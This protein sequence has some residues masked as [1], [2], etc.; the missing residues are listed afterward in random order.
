MTLERTKRISITKETRGGEMRVLLGPEQVRMIVEHGYEVL[1]ERAAGEGAGWSD[2]AYGAAG[3]RI[4]STD[5]AWQE[6]DF[7]VKYKNPGPHEYKYF[8]PGLHLGAYMHAEG[9]PELSEAMRANGVT[10][11]AWEFYRCESGTFPLTLTDNQIA[12]QMAVLHGAYY[13]QTTFGG[14]GV[15]MPR[16]PGAKP[17]KVVVIGHGN[18]GGAAAR[19]AAAMGAEVVV[20]GRRR[21]G[22]HQ[23]AASM[24]AN[25]RCVMNSPERLRAEVEDA[26]LVIGTILISNHETPAMIDADLV[27]AMRPGSMIVDVT[28][29]YGPGYLPTA[30]ALSYHKD[31]VY[32]RYGVLHCKIDAFPSSVPVS[33]AAATSANIAP[34]LVE[35]GDTIHAGAELTPDHGL[36]VKDYRIVHPVM[37][38]TLPMIESAAE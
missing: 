30:D 16:V 33:A 23:F 26:D 37:L 15:L 35:L 8:R 5:E 1:L 11:F 27:D 7:V 20:F 34:Y 18:V 9:N 3:A 19:L 17:C 36:I 4:V 24:P 29:G 25:V 21:E 12:G 10:A 22:L 28:C 32:I 13:L 31:P 6:S 38:E 14:A 2:E